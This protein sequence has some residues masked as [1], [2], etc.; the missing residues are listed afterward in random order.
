VKIKYL[1]VALM[2]LAL[3][4]TTTIGSMT[5]GAPQTPAPTTEEKKKAKDEAKAKEKADK[6]A[7]KESEKEEKRARAVHL[8]TVPTLTI[9]GVK[10]DIVGQVLTAKMSGEGFTLSEYQPPQQVFGASTPYKAVYTKPVTDFNTD[11]NMR[12]WVSL[13]YNLRSAAMGAVSYAMYF[14]IADTPQGAVIAGK[15]LL[16]EQTIKGPATRDMTGVEGFRGLLDEVLNTTKKEAE[17]RA[18]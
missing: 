3:S 8:A 18:H 17:S 1:A 9:S 4:G 11:L 10:A 7:E 14:E 15:Y 5:Q 2:V 16:T 12:L 6:Q 13:T